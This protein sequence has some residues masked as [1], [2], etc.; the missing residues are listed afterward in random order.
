MKRKVS[1]A[2]LQ[3]I[4]SH[5]RIERINIGVVL[6]SP[7]D[8]FMEMILITNFERLKHF[9]DELDISFI[10]EYLKSLKESFTYDISTSSEMDI[11]NINLL[12]E[13]TSVY[14][15]QFVFIN[16]TNLEIEEDCN[17]FLDSLR[18]GYLHLDIKKEERFSQKETIEF[19]ENILK[20][21][22]IPFEPIRT[23]NKLVGNFDDTINVDFK[24][25]NKYYK[26]LSFNDLN[27]DRYTSII[28]MWML[29]A[30]ELEEKNKELV[31][32]VN[33]LVRNDKTEKFIKML[34]K[35]GEVVK[36]TEIDNYFN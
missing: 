3:Y 27:I 7:E 30:I 26:I 4:P 15:N 21:K 10:K 24:I 8:D 32:L 16:Y 18:K 17:T 35:Y 6:H 11:R 34:K 23:K 5:D 22:N 25:D 28:K 9:D 2:I 14:I 36:V 20:S 29:N 19:F 1:Y 31:F 12:K 13:L 33:E